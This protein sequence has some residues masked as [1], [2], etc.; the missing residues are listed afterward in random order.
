MVRL[1]L[2]IWGSSCYSQNMYPNNSKAAIWA[3]DVTTRPSIIFL[4]LLTLLSTSMRLILYFLRKKLF[5]FILNATVTD[6]T[7]TFSRDLIIE[8]SAIWNTECKYNLFHLSMITHK[9]I[10]FSDWNSI[11]NHL[12]HSHLSTPL[13]KLNAFS[14]VIIS[15]DKMMANSISFF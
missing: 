8:I 14:I 3:S 7:N 13:I 11:K 4:G 12:K 6:K 15:D 1:R 9:I 10:E 5:L 2:I